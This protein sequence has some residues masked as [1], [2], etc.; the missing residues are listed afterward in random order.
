MKF[1]VS[2]L[3]SL[4]VS[5]AL[6]TGPFTATIN[7]KPVI[8]MGEEVIVEVTLSN[9][10]HVDYF[11]L[12]RFTPLEGL[13]AN[14]FT[15]TTNKGSTLPYDGLMFRRGPTQKDEYIKIRANSSISSTS[16]LSN[17]Y[18]FYEVGTYLVKLST[19]ITFASSLDVAPATQ[20]LVSNTNRFMLTVSDKQ[21]HLTIGETNR[22]KQVQQKID[23]FSVFDTKA[24]RNPTF[25]GNWTDEM[26]KDATN[27][28]TKAFQVMQIATDLAVFNTERYTTWFGKTDY[29]GDVKSV[30][31]D[32]TNDMQVYSIGLING[33]S[34]QSH[35]EP[36]Y[37]AYT[38]HGAQYMVLCAVYYESDFEDKYETIVHELTHASARTD[39]YEYGPMACKDLAKRN[40]AEAVNNADNY[41]YFTVI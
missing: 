39:D 19:T 27:V 38:Y 17:A 26:K 40:P 29:S 12:K 31:Q 15:V 8:K 9:N 2:L 41:G 3:L 23:D 34:V 21:P 35:C 32:C 18:G 5:G 20:L 33:L 7:N 28:Y 1:S 22:R 13:R 24:M 36:N 11:I 16:T 37:Y 14:I 10:H 6:S 4:C 30:F 25:W